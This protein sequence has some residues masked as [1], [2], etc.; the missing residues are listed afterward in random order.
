LIDV[1]HVI[2]DTNIGGAGRHLLN[3]L[4]Y[5]D[6]SLLR[7]RV[8]CPAGSMLAPRCRQLGV[9][10]SELVEMPPDESLNWKSLRRQI[11][12]LVRL[13]R[14][15]RIRLVHTHASFAGRLAARL[16]GNCYVVYTKHTLDP[17]P[18]EK[19][20]KDRLAGLINRA[21]CDRVIAV[22][23]AVRENLIRQGIPPARIEVI[24]NG[25]DMDTFRPSGAVRREWP[26]KYLVGVVARLSPEK[27][28]RY[29]LEAAKMV[30]DVID[31]VTFLIVGTGPLEN[32]LRER[33]RK[34]GIDGRVVFTGLRDDV[35]CLLEQMDVL[36]QPSLSEAQSLSLVEGMCM[37]R[38]C[39][40]TNVGGIREFVVDGENGLLVE[41]ADPAALADRILLLLKYPELA[42]RLGQAAA[43]TASGRFDARIM[44]KKVT[45][46][47]IRCYNR[48]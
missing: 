12:A 30:A 13:I 8:A 2:S 29:F 9:E 37:A 45:D 16:A 31:S 15:G 10:V 21:T 5:Y 19:G 28:H 36:V 43:C 11:P 39:V 33:C 40:A 47:Y 22:S 25:V 46:L 7:V 4:K 20:L 44:A 23:E 48:G 41:P 6:R 17:V 3:L 26:G 18:E 27:G 1:L 14:G 32:E 24:Y 42:A 35:P 34:L 38:P